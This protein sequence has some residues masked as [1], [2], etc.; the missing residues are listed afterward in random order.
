[1]LQLL[2]ESIDPIEFGHFALAIFEA[3]E[4]ASAHNGI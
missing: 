4:L 3:C 2:D 1:V